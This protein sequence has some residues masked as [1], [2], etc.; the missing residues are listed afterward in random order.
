M[1]R[2]LA[3]P[4]GRRAALSFSFDDGR[5]SQLP[6]ALPILNEYG[7]HASFYLTGQAGDERLRSCPGGRPAGPDVGRHR[8]CHRRLRCRGAAPGLKP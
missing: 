2:G 6:R 3:W 7:I 4:Y 1:A 8:R 5:G